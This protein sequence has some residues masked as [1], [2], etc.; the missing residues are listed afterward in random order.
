[1]DW[2]LKL[3]EYVKD[4]GL[5][6]KNIPVDRR[7]F[8][9]CLSAVM[10]NGLALQYVPVHTYGLEKVA[11]E[12]NPSSIQYFKG[13]PADIIINIPPIITVVQQ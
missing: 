7:T 9:V 12:Q 2:E 1:M 10:Q 3:I 8:A 5:L 6:L 4:D 13:G 11:F